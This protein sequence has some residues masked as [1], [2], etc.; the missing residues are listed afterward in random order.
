MTAKNKRLVLAWL[1]TGIGLLTICGLLVIGRGGAIS[2]QNQV[3]ALRQ[4]VSLY[5]PLLVLIVAFHF[6]KAEKTAATAPGPFSLALVLVAFWCLVPV[7]I[8]STSQI[9]E[10]SLEKLEILRPIGDGVVLGVLGY[11]FGRQ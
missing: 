9:I 5:V 2:H 11:Y 8:F 1:V 7:L 10:D 4:L 3:A 6:S